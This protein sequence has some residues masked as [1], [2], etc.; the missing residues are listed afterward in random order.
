MKAVEQGLMRILAE[1]SQQNLL[2]DMQTRAELY[3]LLQY[4]R[5][6]DF[7]SSVFNFRV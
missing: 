7:D 4:E 1:G 6:N 5:Y 3:K 2:S